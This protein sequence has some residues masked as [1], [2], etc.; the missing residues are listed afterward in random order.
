M[1]NVQGI[2]VA[3]ALIFFGTGNAQA[4]SPTEATHARWMQSLLPLQDEG[5]ENIAVADSPFVIY[6]SFGSAIHDGEVVVVPVRSEWMSPQEQP[7][8]R[9]GKFLS[10][11]SRI[12]FNCQAMTFRHLAETQYAGNNLTGEASSA[13]A[14]ELKAWANLFPQAVSAQMLTAV[15]SRAGTKPAPV[16]K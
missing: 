1:R 7:P 8:T 16:G 11:I 13:D 5:W 9:I 3:L 2:A 10:V 12:E 4:E 6:V 15:C 14:P